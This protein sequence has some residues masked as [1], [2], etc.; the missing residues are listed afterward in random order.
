[1]QGIFGALRD[2]APD[3]WGRRVIER[4][5]GRSPLTELE[6][7]L[8]A[9]DDRAG[10]LAF[11]LDAKPPAAQRRFTQTILLAKLQA[12]AD[13]IVADKDLPTDPDVSQAEELLL[14]GTS[15]GG[16]RPK[17]VVE[18]GGDLWIAK[19]N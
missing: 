17:A 15:M 1:M 12:I 8:E 18:D 5:V 3:S 11:G 13:A 14:I 10:A 6:Y 2:A 7:L 19:F 9:P 4:R 16:A